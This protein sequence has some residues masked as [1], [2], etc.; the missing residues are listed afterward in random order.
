M[1]Y[2]LVTTG[3]AAC[4]G[5]VA[6]WVN[7]FAAENGIARWLNEEN[8]RS[9]NSFNVPRIWRG[10]DVPLFLA[11]T[12][13]AKE[14]KIDPA[15][16]SAITIMNIDVG[17]IQ[18]DLFGIDGKHLDG[19]GS[20]MPS[21]G[22]GSQLNQIRDEIAAATGAK[23]PDLPMRD[24]VYAAVSCHTDRTTMGVGGNVFRSKL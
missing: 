24:C 12:F 18:I 7:S 22:I 2:A 1:K 8:Q 21:M 16:V 4:V 3:V 15:T 23:I 11:K 20:M 10:A 13:N 17:L 5:A 9:D 19:V 14:Q 6:L